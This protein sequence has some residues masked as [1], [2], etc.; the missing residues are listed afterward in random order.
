MLL[1]VTIEK[2]VESGT[3]AAPPKIAATVLCFPSSNGEAPE[4]VL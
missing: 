2:L 1:Q 3:S 4:E